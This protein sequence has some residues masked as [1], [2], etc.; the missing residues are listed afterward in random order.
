MTEYSR[1]RGLRAALLCLATLVGS[2]A[3][4]FAQFG[5][6][7]TL[8]ANGLD[9]PVFLT[10]PPGDPRLF[11]LEKE[12]RIRIV[13]SDRKDVAPFLDI[14]A[15][16]DVSGESG[17]LG[18]AFHPDYANNGLFYVCFTADFLPG[19]PLIYI[20]SYKVLATNPN[21]ADP[22]SATTVFGPVFQSSP[23][24]IN[25]GGCI[26]FDNS[27]MLF[28]SLGDGSNS[29]Q[30]QNPSS[31]RGKMVRLDVDLPFPHV[32]PGNPY[33]SNRSILDPIW[34][35][36][37]RS[38]WRFSFDRMTGDMYLAECGEDFADEINFEAQGSAGGLNYGWRCMEGLS[39]TG[40]S[41]CVCNGPALTP[42]LQEIQLSTGVCA[43]IGGYVYR[44]T[45][46]PA[47]FGHYVYADFCSGRIFSFTYDGVTKGPVIEHTAELNPP[48]PNR[49]ENITSFGEDANGELYICDL[50]GE[51]YKIVDCVQP[52]V[53]V[54]NG[55]GINPVCFSSL[56]APTIGSTWLMQV[57]ATGVSGAGKSRVVCRLGGG[58]TILSQGEL[59][60]NPATPLCFLSTVLGT[61]VM[62][63]SYAI[64]NTPSLAGQTW[65]VQGSIAPASGEILQFCNALNVTVGCSP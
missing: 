54:N 2:S 5:M 22:T 55:T 12:G 53:A 34:A 42:P 3:G 40:L 18:L 49:M 4:A 15:K 39:C 61:G 24:D 17:M 59:L 19:D 41:G 38:P 37:L 28:L 57:D 14:S 35:F 48:G 27:G 30:S 29:T 45:K 16:L 11:V 9:K 47:L 65:V 25:H 46:I 10:S 23:G 50:D 64:P 56:S 31:Y 52:Q 21:R 7:P 60:V 58:S 33:V 20:E 13:P 26:A 1:T 6:R 44:G 43:T 8:I 32:P 36:G 62:N 63:H 51:I